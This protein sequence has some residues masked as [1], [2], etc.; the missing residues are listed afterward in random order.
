MSASLRKL[1][2]K[3]YAYSATAPEGFPTETYTRAASTAADG[4]WWCSR[5]LPTGREYQV[6]AQ[7]G[8]QM[9]EQA[10]T[11]LGFDAHAPV[12]TKSVVQIGD[13]VYRVLAVLARDYGRN[14]LQVLAV[15]ASAAA[16]T[17]SDG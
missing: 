16:F 10:D 11:V 17:L 4:A 6:S 12:A 13:D 9:G 7:P 14:D 15:R 2:A 5:G 8:A 1:R 3:V